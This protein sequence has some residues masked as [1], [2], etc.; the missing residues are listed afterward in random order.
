MR[1][2]PC[3]IAGRKSPRN[4]SRNSNGT[5]WGARWCCWLI[6]DDMARL[7]ARPRASPRL[8]GN[9][10]RLATLGYAL[11]VTRRRASVG[12][13]SPRRPATRHKAQT[14][15]KRFGLQPVP[16]P[17][18]A[19]RRYHGG[20]P[21]SSPPEWRAQ[22]QL[23]RLRPR[24]VYAD[25]A[26]LRRSGPLPN[27]QIFGDIAEFIYACKI[28]PLPAPCD[29]SERAGGGR[30]RWRWRW[31]RRRRRRSRPAAGI[32]RR[33][34]RHSAIRLDERG[35]HADADQYRQPRVNVSG[36]DVEQRDRVRDHRQHAARRCRMRRSAMS[37]SR[38]TRR[39]SA[40]A[41]RRSP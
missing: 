30:W 28:T 39:R 3:G 34:F 40:R 38:S 25:A 2:Q 18:P 6:V 35:A 41:A 11:V 9:D 27:A 12:Y 31:R 24:A 8:E 29:L 13:S 1:A 7:L 16:W 19:R 22:P 23:D 37:R 10:L 21:Q 4:H 14:T 5:V 32:R 20:D 17:R 15:Y 26:M 36:V 33:R